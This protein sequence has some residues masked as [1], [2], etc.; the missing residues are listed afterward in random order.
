MKTPVLLFVLLFFL[1]PLPP[2]KCAMKDI[3]NCLIKKGNCRYE[4]YD[5]ETQI[6]FCTKLQADCCIQK[7]EIKRQHS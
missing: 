2:L 1:A 4:C 3:Y 5:S 7:S 6:G